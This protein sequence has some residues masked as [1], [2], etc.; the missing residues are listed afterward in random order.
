[1]TPEFARQIEEVMPAGGVVSLGELSPHERLPALCDADILR[2]LQHPIWPAGRGG[3]ALDLIRP[4]ERVVLVVSDHTRRTHTDR[5]LPPLLAGWGKRGWDVKEA[6]ILVASGIHRR[7]TPQEIER[8][9][10][11]ETAEAFAG[12]IFYHN[13]DDDA[14]LVPVG[15]TPRG[16]VVRLNRLAVEAERLV[17]IGAA[18]YHYHAGFGGG[19][20]SLV[21]GLAARATIAYNHSL[22]LDPDQDR[23]HPLA[24]MGVLDGNPVSEEMLAGARLRPPD[25]IVNTVLTPEGELAGVFS[26]DMDLAHRAACRMVERAWRADVERPADFV[27][28]FASETANWVQTHKALYNA[29]RA[30]QP[31][32]R[33]VL[34]AP[35]REGLGDE[36]FRYWIKKSGTDEIFRGL[37]QSPEVLGQTALSTRM[38][39]ARTILVTQMPAA[40]AADLGIRTAPDL[41]SAIADTLEQLPAAGG[42]PTYFI[43]PKAPY[44][45]PFP[46]VSP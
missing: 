2:S 24:A 26:G 31:E 29:S 35:C 10:G 11:R 8:L 25:M 20:K 12:R 19:R 7:P 22:T 44:V 41:R 21:P 37:R 15:Q 3:S 30:V 17:L 43:M 4:G 33:I 40:E 45:V 46:S 34:V 28:A 42:K 13:A 39:G 1:M 14:Q 18:S 23:I 5:V 6:C 27:V 9:L 36:R 38:R 16:H 32:G